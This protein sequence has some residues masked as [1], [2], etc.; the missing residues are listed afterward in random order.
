[1]GG[2][3]G[4]EF[5]T[6]L[7]KMIWNHPQSVNEVVRVTGFRKREEVSSCFKPCQ[8]ECKEF[9]TRLAN[10]ATPSL[11]K[12]QK[13]SWTRWRVSV[14]PATWEA[15][16]GELCE[17]RRQKLQR[18]KIAPL[19]SS[20]GNRH[21]RWLRQ[22]D[23][24]RPGARDQSSQHGKTSSLLKIYIY[25]NQPG[26]VL[27]TC[28]PSYMIL[29]PYRD[30]DSQSPVRDVPIKIPCNCQA[31]WL[32]PV[33]PALWE[34]KAGRSR[35][36]EIE[37]SLANTMESCSVTRLEYS[38][39]ISAHCN[40]RLLGSSNS[41]A[42]ASRVAGITG[43]CHRA[44]LIFVF[45]IEMGFHPVG[46]DVFVLLCDGVSLLSP[47]LECS[48]MIS[49]H[50]SLQLPGS[51]DSLDSDSRVAGIT[52]SHHHAQFIFVF[53]VD[54]G[55]HHV[56]RLVLNSYPQQNE[57]EQMKPC[58]NGVVITASLT[59]ASPWDFW[60]PYLLTSYGE[61]DSTVS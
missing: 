18:A 49:A 30:L 29:V 6:S 41:P 53:L 36:Q 10:R 44:Q 25:I 43:M 28:S 54:T 3:R 31:Q 17:P 21:F 19:H 1:M 16:A 8:A 27:R 57:V 15:E 58:R 9:E 51:S 39:T 5:E 33:I 4:Q 2:S 7:A 34:A 12:I 47:R 42:S 50:C 35:G 26:M 37:T 32:M 52:S 23:R 24:L 46:Q 60:L 13:I 22:A 20:L 56:T 61:A 11:L 14:I 40:L 38:G 59:F 48:D 55:F 45:L